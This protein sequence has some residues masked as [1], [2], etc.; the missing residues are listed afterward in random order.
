MIHDAPKIRKCLAKARFIE[1]GWRGSVHLFENWVKNVHK[2]KALHL[3]FTV[4]IMRSEGSQTWVNREDAGLGHLRRKVLSSPAI[5]WRETLYISENEEIVCI[6]SEF[7]ALST[8]PILWSFYHYYY[9]SKRADRGKFV[10]SFFRTCKPAE[11]EEPDKLPSTRKLSKISKRPNRDC[12]AV[13]GCRNKRPSAA[14][15]RRLSERRLTA[16]S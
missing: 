16:A 15:P 3:R 5:P 1:P 13:R 12:G 6:A 8:H 9:A 7:K 10:R 2:L 14:T 11:N 4:Q